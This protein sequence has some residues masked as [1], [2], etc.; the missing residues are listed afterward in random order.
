MPVTSISSGWSSGSLVFYEDAVGQSATGDVFTL[1]TTAVK[2]GGTSQDVD[3]QFYATGSKSFIIDAGAGTLTFAGITQAFGSK[4]N[5]S[6]SGIPIPS[7]DDWGALRV[8]TDDVGANIADSV[9]GI[10]SR[11]L[12]T[13]AQSAGTIRSLQ[14]QL[15]AIDG[16]NFATGVYTA[17]QGYIELAGSQTVAST[18]VLSCFDASI[19]IGT[20][21]TATGYVAGFSA[22]LTGSGTCAAGLDCGFLVKNASGAAVWTY[23]LY[24]EAAAVDTGIY[25]GSCTTGINIVNATLGV[26]DARAIKIATSQA[27]AAMADGYGVVEIDHTITGTAGSNFSGCALSAWV[28]IPSGTVG[29]SKYV[30][31][32]NNGIYEDSAATVTNAK[33]IFGLRA[34]KI[35]GD[36]DSL[37]FPFSIN[38]N[39][40]AITALIDVNNSTDLGWTTGVGSTGG[41]KVPFCRDGNGTILYINTFTS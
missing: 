34:Q 17:V 11:T 9:R 38:T 22:E 32:Q 4:A 24:V 8:F 12:L 29:A 18:A 20:A 35:V 26:T 7:T 23:G 33:L 27:A 40:T 19:E 21:L 28:N 36:T 16:V 15:K 2:V 41:G 39:N 30:C 1:G 25:V 3:F 31:A 14:G 6:G 10:Q 5:V 37:S 13:T